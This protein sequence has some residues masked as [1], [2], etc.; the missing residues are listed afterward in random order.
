M[1]ASYKNWNECPLCGK[2]M[3][4]EMGVIVP[5]T[6]SR[7]CG[8]CWRGRKSPHAYLDQ[9]G[10]VVELTDNERAELN[11]KGEVVVLG[12]D[13]QR[14]RVRRDPLVFQYDFTEKDA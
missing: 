9:L 13:G 10:V 4:H 12:L 8:N 2:T 7:I 11:E 14:R 1:Y 3:T 5:E 6:N